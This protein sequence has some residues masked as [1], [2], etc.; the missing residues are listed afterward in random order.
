MTFLSTINK[1]LLISSFALLLLSFWNRNDIPNGVDYRPELTDEPRQRRSRKR[2]FEAD[3]AGVT[4]QVDPQ[5]EYDLFGMIVSYRHHDGESTMHKMSN[6]HLNTAD[7]C[8][9]WGD[10]LDAAM[11]S[12]LRF[13]NGIFTCNV[14]T[15]DTDA[16]SRFGM[17]QLSNNHLLSADEVIRDQI[18]SASVGDQIHIK[19]WL[20]SY[21]SDGG[22]TRGTSTTRTDTGNGA[23]ETIFVDQFAVIASPFRPWRAALWASALVLLLSLTLHFA[24]PHRVT[25]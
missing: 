11:L 17:D 12:R 9:V 4:Y 10:N 21:G 8:V 6:D 22:P 15:S 7:V 16:W 5:Y 25:R 20:A 14:S 1:C 23:C 18:E 3:Y 2:S 13:W 24:M 19:G